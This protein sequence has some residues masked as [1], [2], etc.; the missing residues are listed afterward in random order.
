MQTHPPGVEGPR[1]LI[2]EGGTP[3]LNARAASAGVA[4][5]TDTYAAA[6]RDLAPGLEIGV[7]APSAPG[8]AVRQVDLDGVAGV[9]LTGSGVAWAA[10][11]A[12]AAPHHAFLERVFAAGI[13]A[14]GSCWG[15]QVAAVVLGGA[16]GASPAGVELGVARSLTLTDAGRAHAMFTGKPTVFDSVCIHRDEV[17]RLPDG[18]TLLAAN[19]HS[20]VQAMAYERGDVRFWGAQYHP[21]LSLA[22][23]AGYLSI[24]GRNAHRDRAK[25]DGPEDVAAVAADLRAIAA[26]DAVGPLA[27]RYGVTDDALDPRRRRLELANW[28]TSVG[29]ACGGEA[30]EAAT[31]RSA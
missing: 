3:E 27:W 29:A 10:D 2:V 9:V 18:A 31:A 12:E 7:V 4:S 26:S 20:Q 21:E 24:P 11:A 13:P 5:A 19:R 17:T 23:I 22:D 15:L 30:A 1:L 14:F 6:L 8:F 16:V 28:L 25:F